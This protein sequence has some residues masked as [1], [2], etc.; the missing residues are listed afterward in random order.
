MK[1]RPKKRR[2]PLLWLAARSRRFWIIASVVALLAGYPLSFGPAILLTARGHIRESTV[3]YL[4][5]PFLLSAEE[6]ESLE[7][8]VTW[9]GS[10]GVPDNKAVT[11]IFQ[12]DDADHVFQFTRTGEG[13][14]LHPVARP[15]APPVSP[16]QI[17]RRD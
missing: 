10:L 4:Y 9:W 14:P 17:F 6:V 5:M 7:S 3:Q 1:D 11:F 12:T 13:I 15:L 2:G 16:S 8:A